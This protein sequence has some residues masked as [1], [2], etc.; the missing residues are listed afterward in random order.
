MIGA[1]GVINRQEG[2][3]PFSYRCPHMLRSWCAVDLP[4]GLGITT[5]FLNRFYFDSQ[6]PDLISDINRFNIDSI[7]DIS[8]TIPIL[9]G[10]ERDF[11]KYG[12]K[13]DKGP[14]NLVHY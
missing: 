3:A 8:V 2:S 1:R 11:Q 13:L 6:R 12:C 4:A 5:E 9:H 10:Y 14:S 7:R